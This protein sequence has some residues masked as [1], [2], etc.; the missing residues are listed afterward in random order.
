MLETGFIVFVLFI[1]GSAIGS[2]LHVVA[3]RYMSGESPFVGNSKCPHCNK[4]L[5]AQ[6][7]IPI[8]SYI[9]QKAKCRGCGVAIPAHYPIIEFVTGILAVALLIS[10]PLAF[11]L[12]CI[13]IILV[14]IDIRTMLLPDMF[15]WLLTGIAIISRLLYGFSGDDIAFGVLAGAGIIYGIWA[16][17][18]GQG[19][20]F[21]DVKL[22][23]PLG[24][25]FGLQ[26]TV[27]LLFIAFLFGGIWGV[28]LLAT[29]RASRKTAIPFGPFLA[30]AA[31]LL[32]VLPNISDRFFMF[33]GV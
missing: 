27:T 29:K 30:G 7:L 4:Q 26:G 22:M 8:F 10:Q 2:F 12:A 15:I 3:E 1:L 19:I 6:E 25:Y 18:F 5:T 23:V 14:R 21:G 24:I 16:A 32:L 33:L 31:L 20:G 11:L 17:T 28:F 13:L 9:F